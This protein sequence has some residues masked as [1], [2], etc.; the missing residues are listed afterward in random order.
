MKV[1][2]CASYY[3]CGSSAVTDLI[4]EYEGVKSLTNYEFRFIH[5]IDGISDLEHHLIDNPNRHNSGHALK[6]FKKLMK[7]N[8]GRSFCQR[9]EPFFQN[10]YWK[11]T[12]AYIDKLTTF[13]YKGFWF[14]DMFDR[15]VNVY[16][17]YSLLTKLYAKLP[18]KI[19]EPLSKEVQYG[20]ILDL[21]LIHI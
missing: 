6:R 14:Y 12:K 18:L 13:T 17:L 7:F 11:L 1:I 21:S 15:G 20:T 19:F 2:T 5:D 8:A 4:S 3:G 16:Y 9:Y 10:Q